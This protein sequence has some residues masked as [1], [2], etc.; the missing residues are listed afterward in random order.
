MPLDLQK[1]DS[2]D[3]F[4]ET[5]KKLKIQYDLFF[6][7]ARKLPPTEERKR[8]E[9]LIHELAKEKMR[10]NT[11]RFRFN[12]LLGRYNQFRELWSR[13][14]REREEGPIEFRR[15]QAAMDAKAPA[16]SPE[17]KPVPKAPRVTS[18]A[19]ESYVTVTPAN[20]EAIR[21]LHAQINAAHQQ[22]G[23]G[24]S[25]SYE[26]VSSM[27]EKQ[28]EALRQRY[29]VNAIAFRVD[30]SEGKVKLKAKPVTR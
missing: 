7:G 9:A 17:D 8:L 26:Q 15:R 11:R 14:M 13:K 3:I 30:T 28:A 22:L 27:V 1:K 23:K 6:A 24:S 19:G 12:T 5:V 16:A 21:Q 2:L 10:D 20:G 29:G 18:Q 25:L 4:E